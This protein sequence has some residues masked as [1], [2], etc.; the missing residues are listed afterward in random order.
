MSQ[1]LLRLYDAVTVPNLPAS[2]QNVAAYVDG[3]FANL[4]AIK[5]RFPKARILTITV[6]GRTLA[7]CCDCET[8]DLSVAGAVQWVAERVKANQQL[9]VVYADLDTWK[10]QG[11]EAQLA[12][13]GSRI[14]RWLA[15]YDNVAA[16]PAGFDGKQ[17]STGAYDTSEIL[18]TFFDP[19]A[20]PPNP[21]LDYR[22]L[23]SLERKTVLSYD[24]ARKHPAQYRTW[25][26]ALRAALRVL[27]GLVYTAAHTS[28][29]PSWSIRNRGERYQMLIKRANGQQIA[30]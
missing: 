24:G 10:N 14:K 1:S 20:P 12:R 9:I 8:G 26:L 19:P 27:A 4:A 17:Y 25:I 6:T 16:I 29:P 2:T 23:T 13:Y 11:L 15:D 28:R 30:K 22:I 21:L 18:N 7:D 3:S 5:A